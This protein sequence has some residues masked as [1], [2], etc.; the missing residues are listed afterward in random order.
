MEE[1]KSKHT[2]KKPSNIDRFRCPIKNVNFI[3]FCVANKNACVRRVFHFGCRLSQEV[4]Q[5]NVLVWL[6]ARVLVLYSRSSELVHLCQGEVLKWCA[7]IAAVR[8][9]HRSVWRFSI[10]ALPKN[11]LVA[12]AHIVVAFFRNSVQYFPFPLYA[13]ATS[14]NETAP[15]ESCLLGW[16]FYRAVPLG[17]RALIVSNALNDLT[18]TSKRSCVCMC[19]C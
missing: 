1:L 17:K 18:R 3:A 5:P 8:K 2:K 19:V 9:M 10:R 13:I 7:F 15:K 12:I 6:R 14:Q 16:F 4:M 11:V